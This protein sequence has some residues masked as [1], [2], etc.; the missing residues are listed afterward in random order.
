MKKLILNFSRRFF[1]IIK[2]NR[3]KKYGLRYIVLEVLILLCHRSSSEFEN[4]VTLK[5]DRYIRKYLLKNYKSIVEKY[6]DENK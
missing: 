4:Y 2:P 5:R 3:I 1:L 6:F